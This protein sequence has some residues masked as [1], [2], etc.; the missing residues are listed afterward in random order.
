VII[1]DRKGEKLVSKSREEI[2]QIK[3]KMFNPQNV[4]FKLIRS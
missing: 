1:K 2:S 4:N 3:I